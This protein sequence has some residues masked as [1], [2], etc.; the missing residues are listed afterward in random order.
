[1]W[2]E[3]IDDF[4]S[5]CIDHAPA[6]ISYPRRRLKIEMFSNPLFARLEAI[7]PAGQT[8]IRAEAL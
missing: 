1:M 6:H 8:I 3:A 5:G 7:C 4:R 2:T